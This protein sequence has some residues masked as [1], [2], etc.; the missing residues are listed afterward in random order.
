MGY[1]SK[2]YSV[3][4]YRISRK[5]NGRF[6]GK[7]KNMPNYLLADILKWALLD[8]N[9]PG[10]LLALLLFSLVGGLV[11]SNHLLSDPRER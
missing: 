3:V 8:Q 9:F 1:M 11:L 2:D 10:V 7:R 4:K 6:Q 5:R